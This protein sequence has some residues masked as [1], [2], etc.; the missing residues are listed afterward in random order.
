[1]ILIDDVDDAP[2]SRGYV[3]G[4]ALYKPM[5]AYGTGCLGEADC[6][7][8]YG[9]APGLDYFA[10]LKYPYPKLYALLMHTKEL[11]KCQV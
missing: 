10:E 1:M 11:N 7:E 6:F 3:E 5:V 9:L 8:P 4:E 2:D